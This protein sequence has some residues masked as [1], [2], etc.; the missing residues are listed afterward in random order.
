MENK[1]K[2][3]FK[4]AMNEL[5]GIG[6]AEPT[7]PAKASSGKADDKA[8]PAAVKAA[9]EKKPEKSPAPAPEKKPAPEESFLAPGTVFEGTRRSEGDIE[10]AGAFKGDVSTAGTVMLLSDIQGNLNVGSLRIVDCAL[11]GDVTAKGTV[12]VNEGAKIYGNETAAELM[13]AGEITGDLKISGNTSLEEK[14]KISGSVVTGTLAVVRGAVIKGGIQM[15]L[16]ETS[17][18]DT[19]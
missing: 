17:A 19:H 18:E 2:D 10:I 5:F 14:A 8:A 7:A 15:K 1:K 12:F 11:T 3:N 6:A 13:S 4:Q 9:P 16:A